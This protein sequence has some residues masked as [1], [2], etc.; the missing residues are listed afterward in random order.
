M[1]LNI[2]V[3]SKKL[4]SRSLFAQMTAEHLSASSGAFD[5]LERMHENKVRA[6]IAL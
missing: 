4:R 5:P 3:I 6:E 1:I 2:Q